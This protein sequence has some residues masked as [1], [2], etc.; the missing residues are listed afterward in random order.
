M[1]KII[2]TITIILAMILILPGLGINTQAEQFNLE[3]SYITRLGGKDRIE[4]AILVSEAVYKN[5]TAE[6]VVLIGYGGDVDGLSGTL[7]AAKLNA[8]ILITH[9]DKITPAVQDELLRLGAKNVYILGGTKVVDKAVETELKKTMDVTRV[10]GADRFE[11]A[12]EVAQLVAKT[13]KPTNAFIVLGRSAKRDSLAD[14]L[15]IGPV[16]ARDKMPI[17]LVERNTIPN[18]TKEALNDLEIKTVTLIGGTNAVS[19]K[20]KAQLEAQGI[21]VTRLSGKDRYETAVEIAQE[22]FPEAKAVII[23]NAKKSADALIGGYFGKIYDAPIL[24]TLDNKNELPKAT[25]DYLCL[26][27][28]KPFILGGYKVVTDKVQKLLDLELLVEK[29]Q[30]IDVKE[31]SVL[32]RNYKTINVIANDIELDLGGK[33]ILSLTVTANNVTIKNGTIVNLNIIE[34]VENIVLHDIVDREHGKHTF[35][36][37]G[38]NSIVFKGYTLLNGVIYITS[39]TPIQIRAEGLAELGFTG[40]IVIDTSAEVIISAQVNEIEV[41]QRNSQIR[42]N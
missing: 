4:T 14:A 3:D 42:I 2:K 5:N 30:T 10:A 1:R 40:K 7:L 25:R 29:L 26:D 21:K 22:Y 41:V 9:K 37:G 39:T 12:K 8:P 35:A 6:N 38:K 13:H 34:G 11:T 28:T 27:I 32:D 15:A 17:L 23:T 19:N 18:A 16:S 33:K 24:F 31:D 36:G 20:V